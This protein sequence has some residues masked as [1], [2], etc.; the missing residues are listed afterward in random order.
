[1]TRST[2]VLP[3]TEQ[4]TAAKLLMAFWLHD[5]AGIVKNYYRLP[6]HFL[7]WLLDRTDYDTAVWA[8]YDGAQGRIDP[9][10]RSWLLQVCGWDEATARRVLWERFRDRLMPH[11]AMDWRLGRWPVPPEEVDAWWAS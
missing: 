11:M 7:E 5:R 6:D 2:V 9:A 1:V 4:Q 10:F 8:L 3:E